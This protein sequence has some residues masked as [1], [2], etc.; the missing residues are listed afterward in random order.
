MERTIEIAK[1]TLADMFECRKEDFDYNYTR[2]RNVVEARRFLVYFLVNELHVKFADVPKKMKSITS[3]CT[4]IYH[5]YKMSDLLDLK[6]KTTAFKS[7]T[8]AKYLDFKNKMVLK[9]V[10]RLE[11]ELKKQMDLRRICNLNIK[12]L[13]EMIDE[14]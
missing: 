14:R 6:L 3:H 9:G 4:A 8:K 11:S 7:N 1:C 5:F 2:R 10:D 12:Q 13:K